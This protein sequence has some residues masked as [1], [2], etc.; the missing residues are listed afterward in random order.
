MNKEKVVGENHIYISPGIFVSIILFSGTITIENMVWLKIFIPVLAIA[1]YVLT[2][3]SLKEVLVYNKVFFRIFVLLSVTLTI[4]QYLVINY[5]SVVY[6]PIIP[7]TFFL[8]NT[9]CLGISVYI[10]YTKEELIK[11]G[12]K[13]K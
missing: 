4:G 2:T 5:E 12:W 11:L 10:F 6:A 1:A 3:K 9:L 8:V 7:K 13:V